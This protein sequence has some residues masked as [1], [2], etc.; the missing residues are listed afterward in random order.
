VAGE[1]L[2]IVMDEGEMRVGTS[3]AII[4]KRSIGSAIVAVP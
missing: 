4:Q 1:W 3:V 2:A